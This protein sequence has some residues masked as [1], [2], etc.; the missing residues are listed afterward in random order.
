M[1]SNF[2]K[3]NQT[4]LFWSF[5]KQVKKTRM[6][7]KDI[8]EYKVYLVKKGSNYRYQTQTPPPPPPSSE[9]LYYVH[10]LNK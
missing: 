1:E 8:F 2:Y 6:E 7:L 9:E 3:M 10:N 4:K 5:V